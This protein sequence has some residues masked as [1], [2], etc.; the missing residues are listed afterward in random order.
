MMN[1]IALCVVGSATADGKSRSIPL[2]PYILG[3]SFA[4]NTRPAEVSQ[5]VVLRGSLL[6]RVTQEHT[7]EIPRLVRISEKIEA[8]V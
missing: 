8:I 3:E 6:G 5:Y 7:E 4:W 2:E 1:A